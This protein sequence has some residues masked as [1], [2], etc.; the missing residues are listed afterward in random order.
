LGGWSHALADV[1][2]VDKFF[3]PLLYKI[4]R[5]RDQ[6]R[7]KEGCGAHQKKSGFHLVLALSFF[8]DW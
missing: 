3:G 4:G 5:V 2:L 7:R 6:V 8:Q 1:I